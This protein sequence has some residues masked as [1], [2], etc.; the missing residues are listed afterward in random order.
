MVPFCH[1]SSL[2]WE[3]TVLLSWFYQFLRTVE[4]LKPV[5]LFPSYQWR[6][7]KIGNLCLT[8]GMV[9]DGISESN[10]YC[11][12]LTIPKINIL[13]SPYLSVQLA[14]DG[15]VYFGKF[16]FRKFLF[17]YLIL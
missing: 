14:T 8:S 1:N 5:H 7:S 15:H 16:H 13:Y 12:G 2:E 11:K 3:E 17:A 9:G 4:R 10:L 6:Y